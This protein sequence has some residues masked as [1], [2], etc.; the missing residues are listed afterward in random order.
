MGLSVSLALYIA[1]RAGRRLRGLTP[2]NFEEKL[3][4]FAFDSVKEL[5]SNKLE[6]LLGLQGIELP[7][8]LSIQD[9]A[10][11]LHL[12]I[13]EFDI[14]QTIYNSLSEQGIQSHYYLEAVAYILQ[15]IGGGGI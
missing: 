12:D 10:A 2:D 8:Q 15:Y 6:E 14:L 3:T 13:E 5:I 9:V 7:A 4:D 11:H 1:F